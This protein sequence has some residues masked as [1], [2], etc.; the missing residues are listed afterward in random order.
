CI[1]RWHSLRNPKIARILGKSCR[2]HNLGKEKR[3]G[4]SRNEIVSI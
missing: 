2:R 4:T 3:M 1:S